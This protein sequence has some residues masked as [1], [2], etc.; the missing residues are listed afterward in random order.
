MDLFLVLKVKGYTANDM[1]FEKHTEK[2][3]R[4]TGKH[5]DRNF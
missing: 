4:W 1:W 3:E 2:N 5:S